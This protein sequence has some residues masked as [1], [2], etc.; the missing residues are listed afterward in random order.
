MKSYLLISARLW[1]DQ[2]VFVY[3]YDRKEPGKIFNEKLPPREELSFSC[4]NSR[5]KLSH[6]QCFWLT[7]PGMAVFSTFN[8]II[9]RRNR[10]SCSAVVTGMLL[11]LGE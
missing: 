10:E 4:R 3:I 9:L 1:R 7:G 11:I 5:A 8:W 2:S 6:R